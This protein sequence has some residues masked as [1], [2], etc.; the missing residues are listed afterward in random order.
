MLIFP[1]SDQNYRCQEYSVQKNAVLSVQ[2]EIWYLDY[3]E[4]AEFNDDVFFFCFTSE[5]HLLGKFDAKN[6]NSWLML[7]FGTQTNSKCAE[8]I[9]GVRL[10]GFWLAIYDFGKFCLNK[11]ICKSKVK[12]GTQITLNMQISVV[13]FSFSVLDQKY[14]FWPNLM[15]KIKILS[16]S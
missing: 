8:F 13:A 6:Q 15:Q 3:F 4:Y 7:K 14:S 10:F 12:F 2:A 5:I 1:L 16:L 11:E 9:G